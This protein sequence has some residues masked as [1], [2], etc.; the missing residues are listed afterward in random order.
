MLGQAYGSAG[1]RVE[2]SA[3]IAFGSDFVLVEDVVAADATRSRRRGIEDGDGLVL[4]VVVGPVT[5]APAS[6]PTPSS[7]SS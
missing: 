2:S 1:L 6:S 4:I 3:R 7:S 5:A